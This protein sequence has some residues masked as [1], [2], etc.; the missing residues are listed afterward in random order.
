MRLRAMRTT[1]RITILFFAFAA[2]PG[3]STLGQTSTEEELLVR[4]LVHVLDYMAADYAVAVDNGEIINGAEYE[5]MQD[6]AQS[7]ARLLENMEQGETSRLDMVAL[8]DLV[9]RKAHADTVAALARRIRNDVLAQ[10]NV[11]RAPSQWPDPSR[12]EVIYGQ[13]CAMCHGQTG[14]A[15]GPAAAGLEPPPTIFNSGER[16]ASLSPFQA[17]NTIRLGVD[18]TSMLA[19]DALSDQ[20]VWDI[21]F[22]IKSLQHSN[23]DVAFRGATRD[24]TGSL[25]APEALLGAVSMLGDEA[26]SDSLHR[27]GIPDPDAAVTALRMHLPE[28]GTYSS[29]DRAESELDSALVAYAEGRTS[30]ARQFALRSYLEGIE[31]VEPA[32][33]ARDKTLL[34]EI[35]ARMMAVRGAIEDDAGGAALSEAVDRAKATIGSARRTLAAGSGGF[36]FSYLVAASILLRE[37]LEA[38]LIILAILGVLHAAGQQHAAK[39]V[40]GGWITAVSVGI[41]GWFLSDMLL[42]LGAAK[43]EVMEG[44]IALFAVVVL[45]YMGLWMHSMTA[46]RRWQA[47]IEKRIM[48]KLGAGS[49]VGLASLAFFAVF[50]EAFES[51]LFLSALTLEGG[52]TTGPAVV[53]GA[54]SAMLLILVLAPLTLRHSRRLPVRTL[55]RYSSFILGF[56]CVVLAGKGIHALQE[57]GLIDVTVLATSLRFDL[58]GMYPSLET[59]LAQGIVLL[60]LLTGFA[61]THRHGDDVM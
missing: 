24:R 10:T 39:W 15:D 26:L 5:E 44:A 52:D 50:R 37:G 12:G 36:W 57:A 11:L 22:F 29:L 31:P 41:A 18:G 28:T 16:I 42:G 51:V 23:K 7:A 6:F 9:D 59:M 58:I 8:S 32:I 53:G 21:A 17:Y 30:A 27:L 35:E 47:F 1:I 48:Q 34:I 54:A 49:L 4:S 13:Q 38:F 45:L 2:Y 43:R 55:F 3:R 40:H 14:A 46:S 33:G 20:E 19:Y 25:A 61:Y 56:L 60:V